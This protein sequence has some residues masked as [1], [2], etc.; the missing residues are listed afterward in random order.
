[1]NL[2]TH[3]VL[4]AS[5]EPQAAAFRAL[6][7]RRIDHGLYPR[8]ISFH[9][10]A[11]PPGRVGSG[12]GTLWALQCLYKDLGYDPEEATGDA[13]TVL[14]VHGAG[15]SRRMPLFAPEGK[16][17]APVPAASSSVL[18]PVVLDLQIHLYLGFPWEP[19][20]VIVSS[21]D[22]VIDF[23]AGELG[24]F[25]TPVTGIATSSDLEQGSRH[26][27]FKFAP[28]LS[29]VEDYFQKAGVGFLH[30]NALIESTGGCALDTGI[31][32]MRQD[33]LARLF[34]FA[35]KESTPEKTLINLLSA[36]ETRFELYLE[37][38][39]ASLAGI[40]AH[41]YRRR[42][43]GRSK[44]PDAVLDR[45]YD[46][47]HD[48]PLGAHLARNCRFLHI[49]SLGEFPDAA[50]QI[51]ASGIR[52]FY[53][54]TDAAE[55]PP[56]SV[57]NVSYAC[58]ST[59][60]YVA[61]A[62][63]PSYV[64]NCGEDVQVSFAGSGIV[65]GVESLGEPLLVSDGFCIDGRSVGTELYIAVYHKDDSF[66]PT[67]L[68]SLRFA[69]S[70]LVDWLAARGIEAKEL[71]IQG[72]AVL[73]LYDLPLYLSQA[74]TT[75]L[76]GYMALPDDPA[77]WKKRFVA[78]K[79]LSLRELNAA[80]DPSLRDTLRSTRR[81]ARLRRRVLAG[82]GWHTAF[83]K[84]LSLGLNVPPNE[85][86]HGRLSDLANGTVDPILRSYRLETV[87][88]LGLA[89][90]GEPRESPR[91]RFV[92]GRTFAPA[93][94][95]VKSDQIVWA[96]SP[97]R[98]DLAGG[99]TDTPPYTNLFGGA[100]TNVA[101]D[102]NGQ[103]PIQVFVRPHT[104][105]TIVFHSIDLG[106]REEVTDAASLKTYRDPLARFA[107]PRAACSFLGLADGALEKRLLS[108][109]GGF[110]ISL[111]AAIPKGS[112]LGTSSVLGGVLFAA[113]LR[114]FGLR[115]SPAELYL[116]VLEL[117]QMLTTG[118]GWQ[119]Q[120][121]GLAG[122]VKYIESAPGPTPDPIVHQL[123]PTLFE[124][125]RY[126]DRM[127]LYY[128]GVTRLARNIL[129]EVVER[130]NQRDPAFLFTHHCIRSLAGRAGRAISLRDYGEL[131]LL[132]RSSWKENRFIHASTTN[133][134]VE[135]LL[136]ATASH[137]RA[138]KLLG[139]GGGGYALFLSETVRDAEMLREA[140]DS[141][142]PNDRARVVDFALNRSGL[143]VT[144]S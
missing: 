25:N 118:G 50:R 134:E 92:S 18:P 111:L 76:R 53:H 98:L 91:Y 72:E 26:G 40:D 125:R 38:L 16:L 12:G 42:L 3:C 104:K 89:P 99:W 100:V 120:I 59:D 138:V 52:P 77:A 140:L 90:E 30:K 65:A 56:H 17:F 49:G 94:R 81:A 5:D 71:G 103:S 69:G 46:S 129:G 96:R 11:D 101:V 127:T 110:E 28:D 19:G 22:V 35:R 34:A 29:T 31:V 57:D 63:A 88:A 142:P 84:D 6:L 117:E 32:V 82:S 83:T 62:G 119:D 2:F 86:D 144:V 70:L 64:E 87:A 33:Y 20:Q 93:G 58:L 141:N 116:A 8:E 123:D 95:A 9:V 122:G 115:F 75:D 133:A 137:Y 36:G 107:L 108:L 130:V 131:C 39:S 44:L 78:S 45:F 106:E 21:G 61:R 41:E 24:R 73:D 14:I 102:L 113:L 126:A 85:G 37:Q 27:V 80:T 54:F 48:M 128:T 136:S 105:P 67:E 15:E 55:L 60:T 109:G 112:G 13:P 51:A 7:D 139:A 4:T 114:Y 66:R 143:E 79:R 47:F 121:G 97:V 10:Y 1:M 124:D 74:T 135:T 23:D 68:A 43:E 132:V